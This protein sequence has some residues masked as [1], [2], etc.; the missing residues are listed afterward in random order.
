M[1]KADASTRLG[2]THAQW[3]MNVG[4]VLFILL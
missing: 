1:L 3:A 4:P 2:L